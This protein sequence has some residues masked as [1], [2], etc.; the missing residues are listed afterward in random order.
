[1]E[2]K[3]AAPKARKLSVPNGRAVKARGRNWENAVVSICHRLGWVDAKRNGAVYGGADRGDIG[4]APLTIQC[5]AVDRVQLWRHLDDAIEQAGHNGTS[6]ETC[7]VYKR[8][9]GSTADAAWVFRGDFAER[10]LQHYY[11]TFSKD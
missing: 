4:G 6:D 2:K 9:G 8:H 7:V 10:L 5:K 1:M 11:L 3:K